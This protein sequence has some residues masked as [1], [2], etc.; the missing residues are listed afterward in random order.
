MVESQV[1]LQKTAPW[2][3]GFFIILGIVSALVSVAK[4]AAPKNSLYSN[5]TSDSNHASNSVS[6]SNGIDMSVIYCGILAI[7]SLAI[8]TRLYIIDTSF[9]AEDRP[10]ADEEERPELDDSLEL[11]ARSSQNSFG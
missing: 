9:K 5:T 1:I 2:G 6:S 11:S 4:A 10:A 8:A 3:C 7:L